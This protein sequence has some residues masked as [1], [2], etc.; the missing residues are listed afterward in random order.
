MKN[1]FG[2]ELSEN[3]EK[4]YK[5]MFSPGGGSNEAMMLAKSTGVE[6][7]FRNVLSNDA[8][9]FTT[10]ADAFYNTKAGVW[11]RLSRGLDCQEN[12][13][14]IHIS[15]CETGIYNFDTHVLLTEREVGGIL[16]GG[17]YPLYWLSEKYN[18]EKGSAEYN[19]LVEKAHQLSSEESFN[20]IKNK[21]DET[22]VTNYNLPKID[23]NIVNFNV[24]LLGS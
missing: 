12:R 19:K 21:A 18:I 20:S 16:T 15:V 6:K 8:I 2:E 14:R 24:N 3:V 13:R 17:F 10:I 9:A 7:E 22:L 23:W 5:Y 4:C 1:I 11:L